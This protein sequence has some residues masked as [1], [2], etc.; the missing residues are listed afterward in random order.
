MLSHFLLF[1]LS[2]A[3]VIA[4]VFVADLIAKI[5]ADV[6]AIMVWLMLLPLVLFS[7]VYIALAN[8][9]ANFYGR[10]YCHVVVVDAVTTYYC[11]LPNLQG[12]RCY[13][14]FYGRSYCHVVVVDAVTTYYCYLP[15]LQGGRCYCLCICGRWKNHNYLVMI[16]ADIIAMVADGIA[17]QDELYL[18]RC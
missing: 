8:V 9:I 3:D 15:N 12:G 10:S 18:A 16:L 2:L 4:K 6:I 7:Y 14:Q 17:T 5:M 11:Y 1:I 13:C